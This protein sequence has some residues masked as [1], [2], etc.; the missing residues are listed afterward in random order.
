MQLTTRPSRRQAGASLLE[1]LVS[2]LILSFG[3]LAM[4]GLHAA[5]LR[6]GKMAQFR[7]VATQLAYDLSDRMRA[8]SAG[9][10]AGGYV[11]T[12]AYSAT[13]APVTVPGCAAPTLCTAAEI[14][15]I[16]LAQWRNTARLALPGGG[17][18]LTQDPGATNVMNMWVMW[19]DPQ[20]A[21]GADLGGPCPPE[22]GLS[23]P[24][25]QCMFLRVAL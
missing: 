4:A 5:S 13:P 1:V 12:A 25:Q 14:A 24:P 7:S 15:A 8:N 19:Q 21:D 9:A 23:D 16:D 18:Y 11:Y 20:T 2:I 3:M 17:V 22:A 10:V 6:Y